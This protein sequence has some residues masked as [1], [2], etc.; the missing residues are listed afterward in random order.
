[1]SSPGPAIDSQIPPT[2]IGARLGSATV[3]TFS[4]SRQLVA[5]ANIFAISATQVMTP[6]AI[7]AYATG[8]C[9]HATATVLGGQECAYALAL[10]FCGGIAFLGLP[11]IHWWQ[12]GA[13]GSAY[14]PLLVLM[15]G[16]SLPMA[17]WLTYSVLF[18]AGRQRALGV[19]A[20]VEGLI[21]VPLILFGMQRMGLLG[22]CSGYALRD[23]WWPRATI[24]WL[25]PSHDDCWEICSACILP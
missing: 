15:L 9:Q 5:Y 16:E 20:M 12:H 11:F 1:M 18:G 3:T 23:F 14:K 10:F 6:R 19:L 7:A 25:S 21:S 22:V 24:L 8:S 4:V 13:A 2:L 17:Q